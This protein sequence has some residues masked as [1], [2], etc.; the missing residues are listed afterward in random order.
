VLPPLA[1]ADG[2]GDSV[3]AVGTSSALGAPVCVLHHHKAVRP[4]SPT[5]KTLMTIQTQAGA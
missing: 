1:D 3:A 2:L 5:A 4:S